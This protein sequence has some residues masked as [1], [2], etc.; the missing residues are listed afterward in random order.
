[1]ELIT[2]DKSRC[3]LAAVKYVLPSNSAISDLLADGL[4]HLML[5][6][7]HQRPIKVPV[8]NIYGQLHTL[9]C[10]AFRCL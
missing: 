7:I 4:A 2:A 6:E 9:N 5:I 1:M 3:Y 8:A 10:R